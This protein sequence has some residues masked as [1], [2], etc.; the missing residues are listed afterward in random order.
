MKEITFSFWQLLH[1]SI[2]KFIYPSYTNKKYIKNDNYKKQIFWECG[3][4]YWSYYCGIVKM[5][6]E[7]YSKD[8]LDKIVWI[9]SSAGVFPC[10]NS[11]YE[12]NTD[13][14]MNCMKNL[15]LCLPQYWYGGLYNFN[16]IILKKCYKEYLYKYHE[17]ILFKKHKMFITVLNI[18]IL[19]PLL[20]TVSLC[21]DFDNIDIFSETCIASHGIPFIMGPLNKTLLNHPDKNKWYIKR[22]DAGVFT[23]LF[24][25]IFGY[26]MFLI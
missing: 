23:L 14:E 2:M 13:N 12:E 26:K 17:K 20:T 21:Y 11:E 5:I 8:I 4:G 19:C 15:L 9:G 10:I 7:T 18:N 25:Y 16:S 1:Y 24:G 6:K 22:M 3:G